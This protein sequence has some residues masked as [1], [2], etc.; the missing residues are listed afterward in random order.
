MERDGFASK[1]CPAALTPRDSRLRHPD[2]PLKHSIGKYVRGSINGINETL[3]NYVKE[4]VQ[5]WIYSKLDKT[6][7]R[8]LD[9]DEIITGTREDGSNPMNLSSSP[10]IPFIFEKRRKGKKDHFE[11][12]EQGMVDYINENTLEEYVNFKYYLSK[13]CLPLTRAYDFPKDELR[14]IDKALGTDNSPPKTRSV[15]CM[16]MFYILAWRELT[17]DFWASMHRAADGTFPFTPGINPE[18]PEWSAAFH[19]LN[20]HPNAVDFDVSNWDGFLPSWLFYLAGDIVKDACTLSQR[21]SNIFDCIMHEVMN[22]Y[23]QYGNHIYQKQRGMVSG[24]PGTAEMNSLVHWLLICLI[25]MLCTQYQLHLNSIEMMKKHVSFKVYGDDIIV[26]FSDE[27]LPYFNG[28][29]IAQWYQDIGY[30][31]T[32][33]DKSQQILKRKD[34]KDCQFL[35]STWKHLFSGI[36]I[37]QMDESVAYDLLY[38]V[39]AKE[40]PNEQFMLNVL[41]SLR[42]MFGHGEKRFNKYLKQVNHWLRQA[43]MEPLL[44]TYRDFERDYISRYYDLDLSIYLHKY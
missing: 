40:H 41:D 34:L 18:G 21:D 29:L 36:M 12:D 11:I 38:W 27:V 16:N 8:T 25:Y 33:A 43:Q 15:T 22:S 10:G 13:R 31:V 20:Q 6:K 30:P 14:P 9:F 3:L 39:R 7:F 44:Y 37:R 23:I 17:L 26:T 28:E 1:R 32:S 2:H 4:G 35:K 24:F 19:Y 5:A 42:I